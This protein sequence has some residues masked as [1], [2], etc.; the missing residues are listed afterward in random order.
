MKEREPVIGDIMVYWSIGGSYIFEVED[1]RGDSIKPTPGSCVAYAEKW[2]F[3][4]SLNRGFPVKNCRLAIPSEIA[5]YN[6]FF[7]V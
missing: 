3:L 7:G 1:I 6:R 5:V 4:G 2:Q